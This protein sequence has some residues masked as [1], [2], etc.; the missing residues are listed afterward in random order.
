MTPDTHLVIDVIAA[1]L[2]LNGTRLV[3]MKA[4]VEPL[5]V[6][7]GQR[8]YHWLDWAL[9]GR[10]PDLFPSKTPSSPPSP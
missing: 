2:L 6:W 10:L 8:G 1:Q 9:G 7:L 5:A 3:V 4:F